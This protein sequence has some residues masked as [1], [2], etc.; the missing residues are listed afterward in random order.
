MAMGQLLRLNIM[1]ENDILLPDDHVE[2]MPLRHWA[3]ANAILS[4]PLPLPA[5]RISLGFA[6]LIH[7]IHSNTRRARFPLPLPLLLQK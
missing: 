5:Q 3:E 4:L 1:T 2:S 6:I 7:Q